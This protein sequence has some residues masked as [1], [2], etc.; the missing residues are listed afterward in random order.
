MRLEPDADYVSCLWAAS[1]T[2]RAM[3]VS[4]SSLANRGVPRLGSEAQEDEA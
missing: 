4:R 2:A 3:A 1:Y